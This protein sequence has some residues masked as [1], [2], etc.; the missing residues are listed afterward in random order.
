M[1]PVE[2]EVMISGIT[3]FLSVVSTAFICG[4][5]M[6]GLRAEVRLMNDRLAKIEGV[7]TLVPRAVNQL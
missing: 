6:G 2:V 5:F 3:V 7:F 1:T 4:A